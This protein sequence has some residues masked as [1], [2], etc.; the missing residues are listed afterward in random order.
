MQSADPN[1]QI[2]VPRSLLVADI[3]SSMALYERLGDKVAKAI[4]GGSLE[5]MSV[6]VRAAGG[7]VIKTLGD[8]VLA[9]FTGADAAEAALDMVAR[10]RDE[11]TSIRVGAHLGEVIESHDDIFGDAVNTVARIATLA[12]ESEILISE[13]LFAQASPRVRKVAR[14]VPAVA[15]KG[16]RDPLQ[17][18]SIVDHG[19]D[20]VTMIHRNESEERRDTTTR[21]LRLIARDRIYELEGAGTLMIGRSLD[22][23]V[24][25]AHD[26]VS[27]T[28][29]TI[30]YRDQKYLIADTSMNGTYIVPEN[31]PSVHLN[32]RETVLF[33]R[34][35][36]YMG[37][38][39]E[40]PDAMWID[41]EVS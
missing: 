35:R 40:T 41:F 15:V 24:P 22:C 29:A 14:S 38:G 2:L 26:R 28:H 36:L 7:R 12:R 30:L 21:T 19:L 25:I 13:A 27:R 5:L 37:S 18:Y 11:R 3:V 20:D 23:D 4:I 9:C 34:G 16:K 33:G 6:C 10:M 8:G 39:P 17:L 1:S 32:R 31:G